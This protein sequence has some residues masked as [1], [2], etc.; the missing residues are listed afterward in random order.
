MRRL[1]QVGIAVLMLLMPL[2]AH[3]HE[4][5]DHAPVTMKKAVELALATAHDA[6]LHAQPALSL[7]EL[8]QSWRNLPTSAAQIYENGRGYYL[9]RVANP[10][11]AKILYVRILLDGRVDAANFSG[12][13]VSFAANSSGGA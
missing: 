3:A 2:I 12:N 13:F 6:S 7:P 5:H 10:A 4:G 11:Q 8:D 1:L 9:V